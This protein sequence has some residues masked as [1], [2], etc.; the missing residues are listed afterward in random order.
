MIDTTKENFLKLKELY[1]DVDIE[2]SAD[3][4]RKRFSAP[5]ET[6]SVFTTMSKLDTM[7]ILHDDKEETV[8][9]YVSFSKDDKKN[10]LTLS[11]G[12]TIEEMRFDAACML[13]KLAKATYST[14]RNFCL[15]FTTASNGFSREDKHF[16]CA[17]LMPKNELI[18]F[19]T[20]KDEDGNYKYLDKNKE[21]SFKNINA[22][23]DHFGVPFG[24]CS[25]R[26]FH[27]F[28][29]LSLSK[30][31]NYKIV[32][33]SSKRIYRELKNL[34]TKEQQERDL[35][36]VAPNHE[37]N[38]VKLINN[39]IDS[40]HY[41]SWSRLSDI[42]KRRL[43]V[44]LV[45]SDSVNEG[46]VKS[47][48]EANLIIS[49]YIS[50]GGTL[51]DGKLVTKDNEYELS[52]EQLVVLGEY[53]LYNKT[54]ERGLIKGLVKSNPD[55]KHLLDMDYKQAIYS[56]TEKDLTH[57]ICDLHARLFS[58]LSDKYDEKRGGTFRS[59]PV[60][61]AGTDV[62]T[63][64]ERMI[65]QLMDNLSWRLLDILKKNING[66]LSNS[67]Y[68]DSVNECIY[69]MIRMQPFADGNKRTSR[70]VSNIFYQEKGIPY[71]IIPVKEWGNYVDAWSSDT[72]DEYNKLMHRLIL[73]SYGY[74]YGNQSVNNAVNVK[75]NGKKIVMANRK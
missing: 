1:N 58:K 38:S 71:V 39:L 47:E 13:R 35:K 74:F 16:A 31:G 21:I 51:K 69:E 28:E 67:E 4:I 30:K 3:T 66:E 40:L 7:V 60:S 61:L 17:L 33:C 37:A 42:A 50:S 36:E 15:N 52:D 54:L 10:Y 59:V 25:S 56:I 6:F 46:I 2:M 20:Q 34:Y 44:S 5:N 63:A 32:G 62:V 9:R 11:A 68:I 27:V 14:S 19:I 8:T 22:V 65:P 43:L 70:L 26:I 55:L 45:K 41:R 57:Y 48:E 24:Q 64:D 29:E 53:D 12:R 49:N 23:A 75:A 73:D 18:K 72:V